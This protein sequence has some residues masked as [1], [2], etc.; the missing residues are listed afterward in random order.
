MK[1]KVLKGFLINPVTILKQSDFFFGRLKSA[2]HAILVVV[3]VMC[4]TSLFFI[5]L[6][7]KQQSSNY[8]VVVHQGFGRV[9]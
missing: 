3:V 7:S 8:A 9:V 5:F 6:I 2:P 1:Q 4:A